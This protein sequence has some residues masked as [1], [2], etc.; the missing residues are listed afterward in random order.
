MR[1][2][3]LQTQVRKAESLQRAPPL[4][5]IL[6]KPRLQPMMSDAVPAPAPPASKKEDLRRIA[7]W[8]VAIRKSP[9]GLPMKTIKL[10]IRSTQRGLLKIWT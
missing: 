8:S 3:E 4:S 9:S 10:S 1:N 6:T 2:S 5:E 7:T